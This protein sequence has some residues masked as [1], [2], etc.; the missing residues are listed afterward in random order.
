MRIC[1]FGAGAVGG[2]LAARLAAAGHEV[3]VVA[4]GANLEAIRRNGIALRA[5]DET[6]VGK[7]R[8]SDRPAELGR[9]DIVISTLK[10]PGL[11]ALA[12]SV[13]ALLDRDTSVVFAQNGI[14]WWYGIGIGSRPAPPDLAR[15]DPGSAL[16]RAVAPERIIGSAVY[17]SNELAE[18]GVVVMS[19]PP[20]SLFLFGDADDR[21]SR[22]CLALREAV[23]AAGGQSPKVPDIRAAI[24]KKLFVNVS[25]SMLSLLTRQPVSAVHEDAELGALFTRLWGEMR[26][27]AETHGIDFSGEALDSE[28]VKRALPHH[29]PSILQDYELGRP[30]EIEAIVRAPQAFARAAGLATPT[31]DVIVAVATRLAADKGLYSRV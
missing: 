16:A 2:H 28:A 30:M 11:P 4:R 9:Q 12:Q 8:A 24:W 17:S 19:K 26:A 23:I 14:P 6:I 18:P 27:I 10:A 21:D 5:G 20:K 22:N 31:L 13:G 3:S 1:V 25:G 15:L 7:V 29:R